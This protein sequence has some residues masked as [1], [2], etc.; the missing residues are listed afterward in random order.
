MAD[1][2]AINAYWQQQYAAQ[3]PPDSSG[4]TGVSAAAAQYPAFAALMAI[5]EVATLLNEASN[6]GWTNDQFTLHLMETNWWK[7]KSDTERV[8]EATKLSDPAK[9]AQ[10]KQQMFQRVATESQLLGVA[11]DTNQLNF[12]TEG[13]IAGGW[14]ADVLKSAIAGNAQFNKEQPG[15][16][17]A[18][19]T[20]LDGIAAQY[21]IPISPHTTFSWAQKISQGTADQ[22]SFQEYAKNQ[23]KI[24]HPY[25]EK[26]LDQGVTVRQL[27]DPYIQAASRL[28]EVSPD[29][30]DLSD[31]KWSNAFVSTDKAGAQQPISQLAWQQKLMQDP[32]YG[33]DRTGNAREAAFQVSNGI[34]S[35]FGA[36]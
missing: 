18:T 21:G 15:Q 20:S 1:Q 6:G 30:I 17:A 32:T 24:S 34:R 9:A 25:W 8:W 16:I 12:I 2:A 3:H 4:L 5:P 36:I 23:A 7:T 10:E 13:A 11:L 33:W 35:S 28:L 31:H 22:A 19:Q 14:S 27:A 26:Q 29:S